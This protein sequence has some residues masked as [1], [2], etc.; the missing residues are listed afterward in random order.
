MIGTKYVILNMSINV[1]FSRLTIYK[2]GDTNRK[3]KIK[4]TDSSVRF[5]GSMSKTP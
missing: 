2:E 5:P 3:G 1:E 4:N